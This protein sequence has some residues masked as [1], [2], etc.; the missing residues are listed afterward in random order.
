MKWLTEQNQRQSQCEN[1]F[2]VHCTMKWF[3]HQWQKQNGSG[4]CQTIHKME[5]STE[6]LGCE[7]DL[8]L[9]DYVKLCCKV[10]KLSP[11]PATL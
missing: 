10:A 7:C 11:K 6:D 1:A 2:M 8:T 5:P 4:N 3:P 9:E